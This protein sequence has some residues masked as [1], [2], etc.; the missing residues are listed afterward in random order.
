MSWSKGLAISVL[1]ALAGCGLASVAGS[2]SGELFGLPLPLFCAVVIFAMQWLAFVPASLART[3]HFYDLWGAIT[4]IVCVGIAVFTAAPSGTAVRG[5][6]V[7]SLVV[8]WAAR[9]GGFLFLRVLTAGG[10]GRF[11]KI[12][13]S[14][15]RFLVAWSL[16]GLWIS[17]TLL[18]ALI[19][20]GHREPEAMSMVDGLGL[21]LWG[22]GFAIESIADEQKRRFRNSGSPDGFIS[23]GLWALS[24]HPNYFGEILLWT[25]V[26]I[27]AS[28][29][30]AGWGWLGLISPLFVFAL[31]RYGSG[32]PILE[33]RSDQRFG[34]LAAYQKYK[35]KTPLLILSWPR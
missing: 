3:E 14:A 28:A 25:G 27:I 22:I 7:G 1:A 35:G 19:C 33:K 21:F 2:A 15:P 26:A 8:I 4:Y 11:D 18:A 30:M 12:K 31:L 29:S 10:D 5:L 20:L 23:T 13:T 6:L 24:R 17:T 16:Q 9:L 34:H 32:I